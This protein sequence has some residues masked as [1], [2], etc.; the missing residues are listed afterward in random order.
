MTAIQSNQ[1]VIS[2]INQLDFD[3]LYTYDEY[4]TWQ[5]ADRVELIDGKVYHLFP[6][7]NT[8]HQEVS[9]NLTYNW[10][11]FFRNKKCKVFAAPFDVR[12]PKK[13]GSK[14]NTVVQPDLCIICDL[15]KIE[16]RGVNGAPDLIIEILSPN[17]PNRDKKVKYNL[18]ER[19]G[20]KEYWLVH[21]TE[22][23]LLIYCLNDDGKYVGS[24]TFTP[25]DKTVCSVLF[26]DFK[27]DL[28]ALFDLD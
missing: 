12:F 22:E 17:N 5:F 13:D 24:K 23:W 19:E 15:S 4:Y 27:L 3:K 1:P 26:P 18:Y 9:A 11:G 7:P 28:V 6:G 25:E 21:P 10:Y 20:V 8:K 2:N 14:T 16:N